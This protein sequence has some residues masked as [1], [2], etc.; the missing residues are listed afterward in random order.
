LI[1]SSYLISRCF[2]LFS[3]QVCSEDDE[4]Y[5]TLYGTTTVESVN[6]VYN[7]SNPLGYLQDGEEAHIHELG[8]YSYDV[9]ITRDNARFSD[10]GGKVA[11]TLYTSGTFRADKS[12]EGLSSADEIYSINTAYHTILGRARSEAVMLLSATCTTT[13]LGLIGNTNFPVCRTEEIA[14][15]SVCQCCS[16]TP[17]EN[18]TTC[19]DIASPSS[20]AGGLV[21]YLT[22]YDGGVKLDSNPS[23][24]PLSTGAYSASVV[25][26]T[27]GQ[28][29]LGTPSSLI[30]LFQYK[31]GSDFVKSGIANVTEDMVETCSSLNFCPTLSELM[32]NIASNTRNLAE[33][34]AVLQA[35][36]CSGAVP[37][38]RG[39]WQPA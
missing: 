29:L 19:S 9:D 8:G 12:P 15:T 6:W 32:A 1:D 27:V 3:F 38:M 37:D 36:D 5:D 16:A 33:V 22:K 18:S 30:G 25:K 17:L 7:I 35:L 31:A 24:F 10:N 21:S 20:A 23:A 2:V 28:L 13:Q 11:Y 34:L 4:T 39:W 14:T 26:K